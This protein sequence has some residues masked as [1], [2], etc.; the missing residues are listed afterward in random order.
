MTNLKFKISFDDF[1]LLPNNLS[2]NN[3]LSSFLLLI[4]DSGKIYNV[5]NTFGLD[6]MLAYYITV[7]LL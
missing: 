6:C 4:L 2:L 7:I 3:R 1:W 5:L